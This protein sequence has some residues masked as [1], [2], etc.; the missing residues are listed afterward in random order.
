MTVGLLV[1]ATIYAVADVCYR[2]SMRQLAMLYSAC[3]AVWDK[4]FNFKPHEVPASGPRSL[5]AMLKGPYF[6]QYTS[7]RESSLSIIPSCI[8]PLRMLFSAP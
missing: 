2:L 4:V 8:S 6:A 5:D 3:I 1:A 7:N